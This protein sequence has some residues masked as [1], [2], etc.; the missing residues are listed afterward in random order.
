MRVIEILDQ[1]IVMKN[2]FSPRTSFCGDECTGPRS[3]YCNEDTCEDPKTNYCLDN[4]LNDKKII[5]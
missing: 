4:C 5:L 3:D 2:L 1:N